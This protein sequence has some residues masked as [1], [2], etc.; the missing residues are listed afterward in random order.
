MRQHT[1]K[2]RSVFHTDLHALWSIKALKIVMPRV[3]RQWRGL[4]WVPFACSGWLMEAKR[5]LIST[6]GCDFLPQ[7]LRLLG[8]HGLFQSQQ[9]VKKW[10]HLNSPAF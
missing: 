7:G 4:S 10:D 2:K 3:P 1:G 9:P 5:Q 8:W 6:Q